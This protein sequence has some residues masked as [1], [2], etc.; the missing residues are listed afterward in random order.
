MYS[1][2]NN[3]WRWK[4]GLPEKEL[5]K[6]LYDE[7]I[8]S[9]WSPIFEKLMRSRLIMGALRY[10]KINEPNKPIYDR[11]A[12]MQKR[13]SLYEETGNKEC[14]VDVANLCMLEFVEC[15]H[16]NANFTMIDDGE[17]VTIKT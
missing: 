11:V 13:L 8:V 14:L 17:H 1:F 15:H 7:L 9:E 3:L 5:D 4:C 10:G 2:I 12:S 16:P 6:S